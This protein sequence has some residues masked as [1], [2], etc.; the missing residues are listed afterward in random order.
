MAKSLIDGANLFWVERLNV[1]D[2][3]AALYDY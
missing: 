1:F 2:Y 3:T